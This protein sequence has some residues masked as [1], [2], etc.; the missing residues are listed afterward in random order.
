MGVPLGRSAECGAPSCPERVESR[1]SGASNADIAANIVGFRLIFQGC[2]GGYGGLGFDDW[3]RAVN[4]PELAD[5]INAAA[6]NA[7]QVA[8]SLPGPLEQLVRTNPAPAGVLY[9][10]LKAVTD[11]LK[12]ELSSA[13]NLEPP[14]ATAGDND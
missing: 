1:L 9:D 8:R 11:L 10:A 5:A 3:L 6:A 2:G 12:A 4:H 14:T 7:E 13:L